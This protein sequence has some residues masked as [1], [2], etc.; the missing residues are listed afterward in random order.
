MELKGKRVV[1]IAPNFFGYD[2]AIERA[3]S[4][5]GAEIFRLKDRPFSSS[6]FNNT[7]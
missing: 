7:H 6:I 5:Q 2:L 3:L 1:F 4:R